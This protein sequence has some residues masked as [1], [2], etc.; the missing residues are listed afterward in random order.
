MKRF[1]VA[2]LLGSAFVSAYAADNEI[3]KVR[4]VL[5]K[6]VRG[7]PDS[8]EPAPMKG[9]YM[10]AYGTDLI[11]VTS[12]GRYLLSGEVLDLEKRV[13]LTEQHRNGVRKQMLDEIDESSLITYK[14]DGK[15]KHTVTIFTDIDCP[16]CRRLHQGMDEMNDLGIEVRYM[17]FPRAGVGS[18]S[19]QK[20]VNVWCAEDRAKAMTDAKN[21]KPVAEAE[22]ENP[23]ADHYLMG[24]KMGVTG[25]PAILLS[26]GR[27]LPGYLP[28]KQLLKAIQ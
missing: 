2:L 8:I 3:E 22:C 14:P 21:N 23:V 28:P 13:S 15:V 5:A 9:M 20:T 1:L 11:Y 25:T 4:E 10:A 27:L 6:V 7:A 17:A 16:Y 12:D 26:D 24:Q 19:Y 18:P